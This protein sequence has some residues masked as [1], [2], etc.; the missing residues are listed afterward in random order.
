MKKR[1]VGLG[2]ALTMTALL[3][4]CGSKA[5]ETTAAATTAA[6]AAAETAAGKETE[7]ETE[8]SADKVLNF[9]LAENQPEGNPI[10]DG[11]YM[12]AELAKEYSNGTVNIE[13]YP[14]AALCDEASSIDQCSAG[15]LDFSRVNSNTLA[16]VVDI[17]GAFGMPYLFTDTDHKYRALDGDAGMMAFNALDSANLVGLDYFEAG[18]RS[19]YTTSKQING[20][21]DLKGMKVRVQPTEVAISMV[22]SLGAEATPMEYGEVFQ[23]L[24]T[25]IVDGAENDF[26]SYYT[27]GHYEVAKN[28]TIDE[29]MMPPAL[30][31]CSKKAWDSMSPAQQEA[32]KK[33]SHE[34]AV[35]QRQAMQ[36]FQEESRKLCEEAG[37]TMIDVDKAE[38]QAASAP[39]Y[40]QYPQ[41]QE[42]VGLVKSVQ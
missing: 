42:I 6:S 7:K 25:G 10:T 14:N 1:Y 4:A 16:P 15:T 2:L 26:V 30:L 27:S 34:A 9:K 12:F 37:C 21:A 28:F 40:D 41:Y 39:V 8:A 36:D 23:G 29:H 18:A 11:M 17:F 32:V 38:F 13:V 5:G 35:W 20:V 19:F 3:T 22:Q 33:A 31:I 24:Q